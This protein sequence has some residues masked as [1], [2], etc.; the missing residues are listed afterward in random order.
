VRIFSDLK[1]AAGAFVQSYEAAG[2][3]GLF[4]GIAGAF[5]LAAAVIWVSQIFGSIIACLIFAAIF[6]IAG[7]VMKLL[8]GRK[9]QEAET[10]LRSATQGPVNAAV[11]VSHAFRPASQIGKSTVLPSAFIVILLLAALYRGSSSESSEA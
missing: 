11:A 3:M 4:F 8:S 6:A 10:K 2:L 1:K 7:L 5:A 9:E